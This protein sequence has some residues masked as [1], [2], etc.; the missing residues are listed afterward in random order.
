MFTNT[1]IKIM[2][3]KTRN[4]ITSFFGIAFMLTGIVLFIFKALGK[5]EIGLPELFAVEALGVLFLWSWNGA[6]QGFVSKILGIKK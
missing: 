2:K 4:L 5:A 6:L 3:Q 1:E